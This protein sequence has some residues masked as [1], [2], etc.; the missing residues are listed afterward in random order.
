M[1]G[2]RLM[3]RFHPAPPYAALSTAVLLLVLAQISGAESVFFDVTPWMV[4]R[5]LS[6][7]AGASL[8]LGLAMLNRP[9]TS[10]GIG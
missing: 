9:D 1:D 4:A 5:A 2:L 6:I 3:T 10:T 8:G 7:M